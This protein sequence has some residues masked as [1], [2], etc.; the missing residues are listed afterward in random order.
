MSFAQ[1]EYAMKRKVTR[2]E[3]FLG[4]MEQVVPWERLIG[5]VEPHYPKGERGRPP[6]GAGAD[7]SDLL[8][9]AV[10]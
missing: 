10:V 9:P 5:V 6:V 2:R 4:E 8:S 7:A 3:R 1:T